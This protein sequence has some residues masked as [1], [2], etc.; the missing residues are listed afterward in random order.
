MADPTTNKKRLPREL[1]TYKREVK[2]LDF[3]GK[4]IEYFMLSPYLRNID[5]KKKEIIYN[6]FS[7]IEKEE[8]SRKYQP[9]YSAIDAYSDRI[10]AI[11]NNTILYTNYVHSELKKKDIFSYTADFLNNAISAT[12]KALGNADNEQVKKHLEQ[13]LKTLRSYH[14][15]KLLDINS[16]MTKEGGS[17]GIKYEAIDKELLWVVERIKG[18]LGLLKSYLD[19]LKEF[20]EWVGTP[21][22]FPREF[23]EMERDLKTRYFGVK[24][25]SI[26][27][28]NPQAK[29]FPLF[30]HDPKT[31]EEFAALDYIDAPKTID[32]KGEKNLFVIRYRSFF[33]Y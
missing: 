22:L 32:I 30:F 28:Q 25:N 26:K 5:S 21:E 6:T 4:V 9:I 24:K 8:F 31:T 18:F 16:M 19:A 15:P 23:A 20:V 27:A 14:I 17:F 10:R 12:E 11:Y 29:D 33:N 13:M 1:Q 7:R 2:Q 3:K